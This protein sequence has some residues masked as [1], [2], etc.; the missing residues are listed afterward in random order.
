MKEK[1]F[2]EWAALFESQ[3]IPHAPSQWTE[4]LFDDPQVHHEGM[5]VA[6]D[7]PTLGH[8]DQMGPAVV[9]EGAPAAQPAPAPLPGQDTDAMLRDLRFNDSDIA[10]LRSA[11]AVS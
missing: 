6:Y 4:D 5:I 10:S 1:P 2:A 7:D 9:F 3:D 8:I 11:R